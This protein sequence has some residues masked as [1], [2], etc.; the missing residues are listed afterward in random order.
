LDNEY[1]LPE[2]AGYMS[3]PIGSYAFLG[4]P[5]FGRVFEFRRRMQGH[6]SSH[7][8]ASMVPLLF[9]VLHCALDQGAFARTADSVFHSG[10]KRCYCAGMDDVHL[11]SM[12]SRFAIA[13]ITWDLSLFQWP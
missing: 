7:S 1:E 10:S 11:A 6:H 9:A 2:K 13:G 12:V 8:L 3:A 4:I 5:D